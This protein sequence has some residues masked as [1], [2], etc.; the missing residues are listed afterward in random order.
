MTHQNNLTGQ[1]TDRSRVD[2]FSKKMGLLTI[3]SSKEMSLLLSFLKPRSKGIFVLTAASVIVAFFESIKA[4]LIVGVIKGLSSTDQELAK[5]FVKTIKGFTIDI[6]I[7]NPFDGKW[8]SLKYLAVLLVIFTIIQ[9]LASII[10]NVLSEKL[11]VHLLRDVRTAVMKRMFSFGIDFFNSSRTGDLMYVFNAETA[12]FSLLIRSAG[13]SINYTVQSLFYLYLIWGHYNLLTLAVFAFG[14]LYFLINIPFERKIKKKSWEAS[15]SQTGLYHF[16]HQVIYGIKIIKIGNL[17]ERENQN[18]VKCHQDF[19]KDSIEMSALNAGLKS[20]KELFISIMVSILAIYLISSGL[21]GD[22]QQNINSSMNLIIYLFLLLKLVKAVSGLQEVRSGLIS[23]YAPFVKVASIL[24]ADHHSAGNND[25]TSKALI[26]SI[27][28][29]EIDNLKFKY[30]KNEE[31][32]LKGINAHFEKGKSYALVGHSGSGKSSLLDLISA[33]REPSQGEIRVNDYALTDLNKSSFLSHLGY[34]NQEPIIF[35]DT[36]F[37]NVVFFKENAE[38]AEVDQ[39]LRDAEIFDFVQSLEEK[40]QTRLGE[41]GQS[42]SGGERQRIGLARVFLQRSD[43]VLLDEATNSLDLKT[44]EKI[45][46]NLKS[47]AQKS[48]LI[49]VAHRLSAIKDFDEII[50]FKDGQIVEQGKHEYLMNLAGHYKTLYEVQN[51][52]V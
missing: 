21:V 41:R 52:M 33:L 39:A 43:L 47:I 15:F 19:E 27:E 30:P 2:F 51:K 45:Y 4:V 3:F 40:E 7:F 12:R 24:N 48:I 42:V 5:Y 1:N 9:S 31:L 8:S 6:S 34:M 25:E 20:S 22:M 11:R 23:A 26:K 37:Q 50:V 28:K 17:E 13:D 29:I 16:F 36:L 18:F 44:E 14:A 46:K 35:H 10:Q 38:K 32:T 49:V